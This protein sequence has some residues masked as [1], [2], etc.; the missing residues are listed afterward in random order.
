MN[1]SVRSAR[2][3]SRRAVRDD[4][5]RHRRSRHAFRHRLR[6]RHV[7][8]HRR[9]Q[10]LDARRPRRHASRS[11]RSSSTRATPTSPTSPRSGIST[12]RTPSAASSKPSTAVRRGAKYSIKTPTRARSISRS[13]RN[14]PTC[15]TRRFGKRAG[16]LGTSIR[17][18]TA[19]AAASTSRPTRARRGR[20]LSAR[21]S[22][23]TSDASASPSRRRPPERVYAKVDSDSGHGG[24]YR[25]DDGGATWTHTDGEARIW[26]RGWYFGGITA[27]PHNPDVV[28]VMNTSTYRSIDG[29]KNFEAVKG[30]PGGDDYHTLWIDPDDPESHDPRQRPGRRRDASTARRRGA[31]GTTS[32]PAQFYHVV[33]DDRFR[34]RS[35]ARNKTPARRSQPSRS[36]YARSR[37]GIFARSTSA[38]RT[39]D[40]AR[41]AAS[42][43]VYGDSADTPERDGHADG[44]RTSTPSEHPNDLWRNTW[45]LPIAFSAGRPHALYFGHQNMFRSR[46]GGKTWKIVSPDLRVRTKARRRISTRRRWPTTTG[47]PAR[48]RL[49]RSRRRRCAPTSIWAGTDDGYIWVTRDDGR[50]ALAERHAA[51]ANGVEQGR[52]HR[53][54]A[55]RRGDG[56]RRGRPAPAR[57][58]Q[59]PTSIAPHDGRQNV[60]A[61]SRTAFPDGSF[62]NAVREDPKRA[63]PA[64][65]RN[66][67]RRLRLVRRRRALAAAAARIF[68]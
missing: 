43:L 3:R 25:S 59:R 26:Q 50:R 55:F 34:T 63:R 44:S 38:A 60:D 16:R 64:L 30:R 67:A 19:P 35:T 52:H 36:K 8:V 21:P 58:L 18:R 66:R 24:V 51:G 61:P 53:S 23:K 65:C 1:R 68:P 4:L 39:D 32:R 10:N 15:S 42:R 27:D 12:L 6:Q 5:R 22:R 46:D 17:R 31:R 14:G 40:R 47:S 57:R 41:S 7:Q 33:T 9:R 29:G 62:V 28:Y 54:L 49:Q 2:S 11:A 20:S 13:I 37:N 48:R 56:V 45:T